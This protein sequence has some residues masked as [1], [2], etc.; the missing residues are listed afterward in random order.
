LSPGKPGEAFPAAANNDPLAPVNNIEKFLADGSP[1]LVV[2][3]MYAD[4]I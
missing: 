4:A 1:K 2:A 3:A